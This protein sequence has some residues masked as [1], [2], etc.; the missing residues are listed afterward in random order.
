MR[1]YYRDRH[2]QVTSS[3]FRVGGRSFALE[4]LECVWRADGRLAQRRILIAV[5]VLLGAVS[6]RLGSGYALSGDTLR[7]QM[8]RWLSTHVS[9]VT[10]VL[11]SMVVMVVALFG[12]LAA[13]AGLRA[14]EDIR[15]HGR[16]RELWALVGGEPVLLWQTTDAT[17]FGHVCRALVRARDGRQRL[18]G[19]PRPTRSDGAR[20]FALPN[21]DPSRKGSTPPRVR[22]AGSA[23][24]QSNRLC[25]N[26]VRMPSNGTVEPR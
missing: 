15:G 25:A 2:V 6:I 21:G 11:V 16:H 7:G 14:I 19:D 22:I 17:R 23:P 9:V 1:T 8:P 13:E 4:Q 24:D 5:T 3:A 26:R 12:L 10:V 18:D 20:V